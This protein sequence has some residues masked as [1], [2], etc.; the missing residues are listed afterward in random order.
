MTAPGIEK[1]PPLM[2]Q[3]FLDNFTAPFFERRQVYMKAAEMGGS[4]LYILEPDVLVSRA[5]AFREAFARRI[6]R[7]QCFFAMKSNNLPDVSRVLAGQ[8]Y[9]LD[10]SSG[11]EL[12]TALSL[13]ADQIIFS[14]PGKT[15]DELERAVANAGRV[16]VMMDSFG[17]L[18]RLSAV[19]AQ[20][21]VKVRAGVRLNSNPDGLWKKFGIPLAALGDCWRKSAASG[22]I[23]LCGLQFHSSWNLDPARQAEFIRI[24]GGGLEK[25]PG[26]FRDTLAFIDIGGGYWPAQGEWL[27][28]D[29][30]LAHVRLAAD[31][32]DT[33]ADVLSG[34]LADHIFTRTD[35]RI[36][37]EPGRWICNDCMHILLTVI[38][39]K[40]EN[41]V[42]CDA[43]TNMVGWERFET[44]Y[45]PI[46][47]LTD[48]AP[49]ERPCMVLGSLCTPHDVWGYA[50]FG[51]DIHPG[52][53]LMIP[54][55]G[56]YTYS[57]RQQFIKPLPGV[58]E[59][60][61][62]GITL[63]ETGW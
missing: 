23:D 42:I 48:P 3:A 21:K 13:G 44:D 28:S 1:R 55:Q 27:I 54:T 2:S 36:Y 4:P 35:C 37:M 24:L 61:K 25:M 9:G 49:V 8:G 58:A 39:R 46:L 59:I 56:A 31:P 53:I 52:D 10:V 19:A 26:S 20:K 45:F 18:E 5:A 30:P 40:D 12:E 38:D 47:N 43:G 62:S 17:E 29:N 41:L 57:L 16:T 32:I 34:A 51:K 60:R 33:F 11:A 63:L 7:V 6:P 14:G 22:Y 15:V 50:F